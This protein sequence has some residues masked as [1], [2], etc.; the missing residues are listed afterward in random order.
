MAMKTTIKASARSMI[1]NALR[2]RSYQARSERLAGRRYLD[3]GCGFHTNPGFINLN[4][5]W[6]RGVDLC[7]DVSKGF[8]LEDATLDGIF[9]EHCLEHLPLS[10]T[11]D[12]LAEFRRMLRPGGTVR[13]I[14]PDGELYL[15]RYISASS[16]RRT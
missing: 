3:V 5:D 13:V 6:N 8:P 2:N 14:V 11:D 9:T 12:V 4:Y 7:W 1:S 15:S 16:D 10:V